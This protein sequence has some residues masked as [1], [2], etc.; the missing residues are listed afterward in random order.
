MVE[1]SGNRSEIVR[2]RFV[3]VCANL[4]LGEK[5][6]RPG[7][8]PPVSLHPPPPAPIRWFFGNWCG[9]LLAFSWDFQQGDP[10]CDR[11]R[12]HGN[13]FFMNLGAGPGARG[14]S[15][16]QRGRFR[17]SQGRSRD[18]GTGPREFGADLCE[19]VISPGDPGAGPMDPGT[20]PR[21][22]S[23]DPQDTARREL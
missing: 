10:R 23:L 17:R 15:R 18:P 22:P 9:S 7:E 3:P 6:A 21:D 20:G 4:S 13:R 5:A 19:P 16:G 1:A 2:N 12:R 11:S 14:R 8:P